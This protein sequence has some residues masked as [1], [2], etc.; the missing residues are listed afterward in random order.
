MVWR[1]EGIQDQSPYQPPPSHYEGNGVTQ[2]PAVGTS[3][4]DTSSIP[5]PC[6][7]SLIPNPCAA[8]SIPNPCAASREAIHG[9][10]SVGRIGLWSIGPTSH[11]PSRLV[12]SLPSLDVG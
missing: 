8:R 2:P 5:N 12:L 9:V 11:K 3:R 4:F 10:E 1:P 7:T 6:A